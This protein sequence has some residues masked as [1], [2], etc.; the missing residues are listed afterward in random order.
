[1]A[2]EARDATDNL[3]TDNGESYTV[4]PVVFVAGRHPA[5]S[6]TAWTSSHYLF[7]FFGRATIIDTSSFTL[8]PGAGM[9][10]TVIAPGY[11]GIADNDLV[12]ARGVLDVGAGTLTCQPAHLT[13]Y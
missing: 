1:V 3:A 12:M 2:V 5:P 11:T 9:T 13:K 8:D 7:R 6:M 4:L 10:L